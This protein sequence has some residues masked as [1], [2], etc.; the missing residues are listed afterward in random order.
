MQLHETEAPPAPETSVTEG[1]QPGS[2]AAVAADGVKSEAPAPTL[3]DVVRDAVEPPA[4]NAA[5]EAPPAQEPEKSDDATPEPPKAETLESFA[6][7]PFGRH[8]RFKAVLEQR[9]SFLGKIGEYESQLSELKPAAENYSKIEKF[10]ETNG[11]SNDEMVDLFQIAALRRS[12]PEEALQ[13][14]GP[15]LSELYERT[16]RFLPDDL[17][18]DV[19]E[20][21]ITEE[22]AQ[23]LSKAR[24]EKRESDARATAATERAVKTETA[25]EAER[26]QEALSGVLAEWEAA[27]KSSDPDFA[28]KEDF[29]AD[30]CRTL[31]AEKGQPKSAAE[32][33]AI[34]TQAHQDVT[35]RMRSVLPAKAEVRAPRSGAS[36]SSAT[37]VPASLKEALEIAARQGR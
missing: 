24:A 26:R 18:M 19:E 21:R 9:N 5:A 23:E 31:I 14:L 32:M 8:P 1:S 22:R 29:I 11:I 34:L 20:G 25:V 36:P 2:D 27:T 33:R 17:K 15:V 13:K 7:E 6:N 35:A 28:A 3:L 12:N 16:G 4:E 10:L 30:R 37:A